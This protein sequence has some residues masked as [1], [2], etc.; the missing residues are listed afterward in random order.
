MEDDLVSACWQARMGTDP[1]QD[2]S[3]VLQQCKNHWRDNPMTVCVNME[4]QAYDRYQL[5]AEKEC[6]EDLPSGS[7]K[8]EL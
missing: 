3:S 7:Q 1:Q 2:S 6:K 8:T 5:E 4:I